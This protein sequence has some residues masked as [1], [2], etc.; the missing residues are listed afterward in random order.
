MTRRRFAAFLSVAANTR[1]LR[2]AEGDELIGKRAPQLALKNWLNSRPL[3]MSELRGKVVLLRWWTE[4]CPFCAATAPALVSLEREYGP[5]GL[6]VIG[7][8]H[9]KPPGHWTMEAV[10]KAAAKKHFTFPVAIDGNWTALKRWWLTRDRGATSVS[11]LVDQNGVI[12]F[13]HPGGEFHEGNAGET[14]THDACNRDLHFIRAEV[15]KLL[16]V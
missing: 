13:V 1:F 10:R 11:F 6:V 5:R 3:D 14:P 7:V 15:E 12:R 4:G 2:A 16:S 8:F 9:P